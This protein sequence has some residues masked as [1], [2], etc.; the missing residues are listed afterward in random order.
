MPAGGKKNKRGGGAQGKRGTQPKP[1]KATK[2]Q[3]ASSPAL[4]DR[5]NSDSSEEFEIKLQAKKGRKK[6]GNR[7]G[8]VSNK[9]SMLELSDSE[10]SGDNSADQDNVV[11]PVEP[12]NDVNPTEIQSTDVVDTTTTDNDIPSDGVV[13][14]SKFPEP[15]GELTRRERKELEKEREMK[16]REEAQARQDATILGQYNVSQQQV[17]NA[18]LETASD[19][20]IEKFSLSARGK[21]LFVNASLKIT[22]G[23]K[24]GLVGPNGHGKTTL[25][26]HLAHRKLAG[27]PANIDILYC[28][29]EV[30]CSEMSAVNTVLASD[31][32]RSELLHQETLLKEQLEDGGG[33]EVIAKLRVV[34]DELVAIGADAAEAKARRILNG[35]GFNPEMQNR[36]T[37]K[38]S[39]G[40]RMRVSLAR[41]LFME[42]TLLLL[43]EPT[44]HLDL[45]AVIWLDSYLQK[46]KKTLLIVSHDQ[47]FL[48]NVCTDIIHLDQQK[49][50]YYQGN[51]NKFKKMYLQRFKQQDK[52]YTEQQKRL[53]REKSKG[54][55]KAKAEAREIQSGKKKKD[56][57]KKAMD[58]DEEMAANELI[59]RPRE[60][61]VRF[62]FPNPPAVA[63]PILGLYDVTFRYEGQPVLFKKLNFGI[64]M[65][66]RIAVVGPNGVGKS[67]FLNL[68]TASL[69]PISG[70]RRIN[71]KVRVGLYNQHAS[72][73]LDLQK[74][75]VE[76]LQCKFNVD[77]Q[78]ARATLG[79]YGL[80]GHAHLI[81]IKDLSGGQK[82][83][84]VFA[85]L[86]L[87]QPDVLILDEPTNNLDIES[88]DALAEALNKFEGGVIMVSHDARL[89]EETECVLWV[90]E[91][92][93]INQIDGV[94]EDY[95]QEILKSLGEDV[96]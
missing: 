35:L 20:N 36:A 5:K 30:Q 19:I 66:S 25:L 81:K 37:F 22:A 87:M 10:N 84:V 18:L 39:G 71:H 32:K 94:F 65:E 51:Y 86:S 55:S 1:A 77:V 72:D 88:I 60:Y 14:K 89:I 8:G 85:E 75:S 56:N 57:K 49:L 83:R 54:Q 92:Q 43:D 59:E 3:R 53:K 45:N 93:T 58:S 34:S 46:W 95:R 47:D 44:N 78:F 26:V 17:K 73:Q 52:E 24:Y 68:L 31:V 67:T 64:D 7:T 90:V 15:T 50:F 63:P 79:R 27:I 41:A 61:K 2:A 40:W 6:S 21:D 96:A 9:F 38:F 62:S 28:E 12:E 91:E 33:D 29:Q 82:A 13:V 42:P 23:R 74:S 76:Y 16:E 4:E 48:N 80:P 11:A 69:L 70:D